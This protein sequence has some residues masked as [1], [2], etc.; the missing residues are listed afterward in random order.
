MIKKIFAFGV[1]M[2]MIFS[3]AACGK[4]YEYQEGDFLLEVSIDKTTAAI[5][6]EVNFSI[7]FKNLSGEDVTIWYRSY[8]FWGLFNPI[9]FEDKI[10]L[11]IYPEG[12]DVIWGGMPITR[13]FPPQVGRVRKNL[14]R[15]E[16][17]EFTKT[18]KMVEDKYFGDEVDVYKY[19]VYVG[20]DIYTTKNQKSEIRIISKI[21]KLN[22]NLKGEEK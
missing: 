19:D 1:M 6:D 3:L 10:E 12:Q 8:M 14:K 16:V 11:L 13:D 15:D 9:D 17:I 18:V 5:G 2:I 20:V 22:V 21:N 4:E 7:S